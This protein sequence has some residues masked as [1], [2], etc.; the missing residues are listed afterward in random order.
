MY[1][2]SCLEN[3]SKLADMIKLNRNQSQHEFVNES[4]YEVYRNGDEQKKWL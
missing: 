2:L 4:S 3:E 1:P